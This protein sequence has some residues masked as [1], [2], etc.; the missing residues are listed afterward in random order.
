MGVIT[1]IG[2][3]A[4]P[5]LAAAT[6]DGTTLVFT[7]AVTILTG[8]VFG[9]IPALQV[10]QT[11]THESLKEG[12]RGSSTGSG[13][14]RLRKLLV[15][16]EV[17]LSLGLLAGAGLLIKSFIKLQQVDPGFKADC[18]LTVRVALPGARYT[19]RATMAIDPEQ[20]IYSIR[21]FSEFLADSMMRRRLVMVLLTK[22]ASAC[23]V[24]VHGRP[25]QVSPSVSS[26]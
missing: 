15:L 23:T 11:R 1:S 2:A 10:S 6:I 19:Q 16:G 24:A 3:K 18:V 22:Y 25:L 14:Q 26:G 9:I 21:P 8:I 13:H 5:R 17:A 4:F 12:G 20:P 7:V